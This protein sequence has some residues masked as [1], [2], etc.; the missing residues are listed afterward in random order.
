M[1]FTAVTIAVI[2]RTDTHVVVRIKRVDV[3]SR[4]VCTFQTLSIERE[5]FAPITFPSKM[6]GAN[7]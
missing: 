3:T 2:L 4:I 5:T 1:N 6:T 7:L